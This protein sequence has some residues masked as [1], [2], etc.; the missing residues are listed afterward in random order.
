[1][2]ITSDTKQTTPGELPESHFDHLYET[3]VLVLAD[4]QEK[5]RRSVKNIGVR[6]RMI[7]RKSDFVGENRLLNFFLK[8][9]LLFF[10][11]FYCYVGH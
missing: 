3:A 4:F 9:D 7:K 10:V 5:R 11:L 8:C 1:M 6:Q 2:R